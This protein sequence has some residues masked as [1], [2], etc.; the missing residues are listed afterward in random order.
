[1]VERTPRKAIRQILRKEVNYG[2]PICGVPY[3][4]WHHF[5]PPWE[6]EHHERPE[7][8]IALCHNC[9]DKADAGRYTKDQLKDFKKN[10]YIKNS[11]ISA[12]YDYLRRNT[13]CRI[14]D[15]IGYNVSSILTLHGERVIWFERDENGYDQLNLVIRDYLGDIILK[16]E[17]NDWIIYTKNIF[18]IECPAQGKNL[19]IISKDKYTNFGLRFD[20]LEVEEFKKLLFSIDYNKEVVDRLLS[21]IRDD[22]PERIPL[23]TLKGKITYIDMDLNIKDDGWDVDIDGIMQDCMFRKIVTV[24]AAGLLSL[25]DKLSDNGKRDPMILICQLQK[26]KQ[27]LSELKNK[28][29]SKLK[30]IETTITELEKV[31]C[32]NAIYRN[33]GQIFLISDKYQL[34]DEFKVKKRDKEIRLEAITQQE[35]RTNMRLRRAQKAID[36]DQ[37]KE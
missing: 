13:V 2:C 20:D 26:R 5:D 30:E 9:H 11:E 6:V 22:N 23:W 12:K 3:L 25:G 7:G 14:G 32:V 21:R 10:P 28:S 15:F 1:M 24:D 19:K 37:R 29:K 16:M 31:D 33:A 8:I 36:A 34:I 35:K 17:N 27:M 4:T 18:D